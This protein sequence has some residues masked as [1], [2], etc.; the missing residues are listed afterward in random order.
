MATYLLPVVDVGL[1]FRY[2]YSEIPVFAASGAEQE[3]TSSINY[4]VAGLD[5]FKLQLA[6]SAFVPDD[7]PNRYVGTVAVQAQL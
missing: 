1:A 7:G 3:F 6:F 5:A 2:A 4:F